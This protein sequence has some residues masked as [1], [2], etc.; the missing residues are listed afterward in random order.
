[1]R[2][3]NAI[4]RKEEISFPHHWYAWC[5][6]VY[7]LINRKVILA[8]GTIHTINSTDQGCIIMRFCQFTQVGI[9]FISVSKEESEK[10]G[11]VT[12]FPDWM[13]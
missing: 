8:N 1:M 2:K 12:I 6:G 7:L 9:H 13:K 5:N 4:S 11:K 3:S 10:I